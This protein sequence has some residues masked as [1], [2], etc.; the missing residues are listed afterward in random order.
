ML[1]IF[2]VLDDK[3]GMRDITVQLHSAISG[4]FEKKCWML[5]GCHMLAIFK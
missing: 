4:G 3:Q 1:E 5:G 2:K